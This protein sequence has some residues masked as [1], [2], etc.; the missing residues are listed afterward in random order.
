MEPQNA[1][2]TIELP[3]NKIYRYWTTLSGIYRGAI[4]DAATVLPSSYHGWNQDWNY[5]LAAVSTVIPWIELRMES[6]PPHNL[7]IVYM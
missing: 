4:L 3:L 1:S 7:Y 5:L 2:P 6:G